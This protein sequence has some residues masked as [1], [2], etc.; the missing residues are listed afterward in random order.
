MY[1]I[2]NCFKVIVILILLQDFASARLNKQAVQRT[3][4]HIVKAIKAKDIK[5][6]AKY[7]HKDVKFTS[8][9][10]NKSTRT[11][12]LNKQS[13]LETL[14]VNWQN[15]KSYNSDMELL[16]IKIKGNTAIVRSAIKEAVAF[17]DS[18]ID[19]ESEQEITLRKFKS[20]ML[21]THIKILVRNFNMSY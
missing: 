18:N 10:R 15:V 16:S 14:Q 17:K 3:Y 7:L 6:F 4:K 11:L 21:I 20:T 12:A 9:F 8:K 13:Y 2:K 5:G 19:T 1:C